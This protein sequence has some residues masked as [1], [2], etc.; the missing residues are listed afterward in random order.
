MAIKIKV[1]ETEQDYKEA[2]AAVRELM[3]KNPPI[4]SEG[5]ELIGVLSTLIEKYEAVRFPESLPDPIDA[6]MFRM[7]QRDLKPT[8]LVPYIGSRGKVSEVL[9]RKRPLTLSMIRSLE[10]GLGIPAKVLLNETDEFRNDKDINWSRFPLKE[11]EKR[12]YFSEKLSNIEELGV[13]MKSFFA[14]VGSPN[15][16]LGMLRKTS[17]R[18]IRPMDKY[19]LTAWSTRVASKAKANLPSTEYRAGLVNLE[20]MQTIAKISSKENGPILAQEFLR[21]H[22]IQLIIEPPFKQTYL[23][24]ATL[25]HDKK[26][27]VIGLTLRRDALDNF[28]FSLMHEL[29]HISLHFNDGCSF[30]YDNLDSSDSIESKEA[31]ADKLAREALVPESKWQVSPAKVFPSFMAA[32]SLAKD[33]GIHI[34]IVAGKMRYEGGKYIYLNKIVNQEKVRIYFPKE[35]WS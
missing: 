2:L 22:G 33:L 7:E 20:F 27:P 24:G 8:D 25:M 14:P 10:V 1:I 32:R 28:W 15:L 17:Y 13:V 6:I 34:A 5:A 31:E 23:D 19:A 26:H 35:K 9:S 29:A 11:M 18:S 4:N 12:G 21:E 16:V 30:F 3:L